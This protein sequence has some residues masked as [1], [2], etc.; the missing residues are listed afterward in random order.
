MII[1]IDLGTTNS[2]AAI[3][4]DG[5]PLLIPNA[6]GQVLTPS[7]VGLDEDGHILV[8]QAA[9]DRLVT[10][11]LQTAA[12]FKRYMGSDHQQRLG[13]RLFRAEEL[14]AF[15][16]KSLKAD[17]EA[18]LGEPVREA[19]I[20][21]P[22]YFNDIQRKA[23]RIA[24]ELAGLN[25]ERLVNE[26]TAAAMAYGLHQHS[27]SR[28][29]VFDLGGGTFDVSILDLFEGVMEVR[30]SAGDNLLGGEDF[31][32]V[33][34]HHL[35]AQ[36]ALPAAGS[37]PVLK[38]QLQR[39]AES[40][41]RRLSEQGEVDVDFSWNGQDRC[42][43]LT[44][45]WLEEG[46]APLLAR[47]R[48]PVERAL[49][50]A[51][52]PAHGLDQIVLVGGATRMPLVRKLVTRMFGRFPVCRINP[53]EA[54]ALG[55]AVQAGLK[56]RDAALEEM[57]LTDV[58][59]YS[60]GIEI[61]N[62]MAGG[63]RERGVFLPIIERNTLVPVSRCEQ[64]QTI[65]DLQEQVDLRIYQGEARKV[66]DNVC[67]GELNIPVPPLPAGQVSLEVRFSYTVDGILEAECLVLNTGEIRRLVIEKCPGSLSPDEVAARL[68]AL[69]D[70]KMHPRDRM[71]NT[72][73]RARANRL[74]EQTRGDLRQL[75]GQQIGVFECELET[76]DTD[77]IREAR[78][79]LG[80][81]L[82]DIEGSVW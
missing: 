31:T 56:A 16:L 30:A 53:D 81:L 70:I 73:L 10:H 15:V 64:V 40:G 39:L 46:C 20:T 21:V 51:R 82:D 49:R 28:F 12:H 50:D 68:A 80:K 26:P 54:V 55:A 42:V 35:C 57:V 8:G 32:E 38:A 7:A 66:T 63:R 78:L 2:L 18:W 23:T 27:E 48:Q 25:V 37:D 34:F 36:L 60:M 62:R 33:V 61:S 52:L 65:T 17:V 6:L 69:D 59:P 74:Y 22:A 9:Q 29:L 58:A 43:T 3:W 4:R 72:A 11:P 1:G 41:K 19:V 67:L 77:R 24:G 75:I 5:Q 47:L 45:R 71:E 44:Q 76:Q 14:S 13:H 79:T